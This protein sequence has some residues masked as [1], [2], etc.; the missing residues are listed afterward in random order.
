MKQLLLSLFV[1]QTLTAV[2]FRV[3]TQGGN[4]GQ[5]QKLQA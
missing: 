4:A 3:T 1:I 5:V 2:Q